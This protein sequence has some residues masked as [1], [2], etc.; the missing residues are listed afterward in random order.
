MRRARHG[1]KKS[2][3][4][5]EVESAVESRVEEENKRDTYPRRGEISFPSRLSSTE[6]R[7]S[8]DSPVMLD[9]QAVIDVK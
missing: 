4:V 8:Q 9:E 1:R 3:C 7:E 6:L 2:D 5:K